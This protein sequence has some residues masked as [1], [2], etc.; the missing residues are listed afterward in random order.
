M[1]DHI[2]VAFLARVAYAMA[3]A[4]FADVAVE[5]H[6][7][8]DR[9]GDPITH[10]AD[11]LHVP[12]TERREFHSLGG[13]YTVNRTMLLVVLDILVN[14]C[15]V[16]ENLNL[17]P[18]ERSVDAHRRADADTSKSAPFSDISVII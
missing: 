18:L 12:V 9:H 2:V 13:N 3:L 10:G 5:N 15:V 7:A 17:H 11:F 6:L 4:G 8:V 16:V 14:R 1:V